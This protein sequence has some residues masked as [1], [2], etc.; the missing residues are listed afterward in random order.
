MCK[1]T[2]R[3]TDTTGHEELTDTCAK[4]PWFAV[5]PARRPQLSLV[6]SLRVAY[7]A[8]LVCEPDDDLAV[9]VPGY[10]ALVRGADVIERKGLGHHRLHLALVDELRHLGQHLAV[11]VLI[12]VVAMHVAAEPARE[13]RAAEP[14]DDPVEPRFGDRETE[15]FSV[16]ACSL[17]GRARECN[18][19]TA[20]PEQLGGALLV[21]VRQGVENHVQRVLVDH[22]IKVFLRVVD[23][24]LSTERL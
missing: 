22:I 17:P 24:A 9:R 10:H 1:L 14:D 15:G 7:V 2:A 18:V 8:V 4:E 3:L 12:D 16:S 13:R 20:R 23:H 21:E 6:Q 11:G 19:V 5:S